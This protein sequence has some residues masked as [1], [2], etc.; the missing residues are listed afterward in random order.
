MLEESTQHRMRLFCH[1]IEEFLLPFLP[2]IVSS[3]TGFPRV[4]LGS[5]QS[6]FLCEFGDGIKVFRA[7]HNVFNQKPESVIDH[8]SSAVSHMLISPRQE[9]EVPEQE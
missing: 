8:R 1:R 5:A 6:C 9:G 4:V 3:L 7:F 2:R